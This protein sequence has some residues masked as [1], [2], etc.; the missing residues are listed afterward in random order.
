[1]S[2]DGQIKTNNAVRHDREMICSTVPRI[3]R[4]RLVIAIA[5]GHNIETF[6]ETLCG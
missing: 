1:L 5:M 6:A 3:D 4:F 2:I